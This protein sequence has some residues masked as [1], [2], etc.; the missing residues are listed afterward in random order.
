MSQTRLRPRLVWNSRN[1]TG[2]ASGRQ[3]NRSYWKRRRRNRTGADYC[4]ERKFEGQS[5]YENITTAQVA[6]VFELG[7]H[8]IDQPVKKALDVNDETTTMKIAPIPP[9]LVYD[10]FEQDLDATMV[11]ER[12]MDCQHDSPMRTNVLELFLHT[13]MIGQWR[14]ADIKPFLPA[15]QFHRMLSR[16]ARLWAATQM[17]KLLPE[18]S[19]APAPVTPARGPPPG[20][21][22]YRPQ[23]GAGGADNANQVARGMIQMDAATLRDFLTKAPGHR[24]PAPVTPEEATF[25]V[26]AAGGEKARMRAMCGIASDSGDECLPKWFR[27]FFT[28]HQDDISKSPIIAE[29]VNASWVLDDAEVPLYPSLLKSIQTRNWTAQDLGKRAALFSLQWSI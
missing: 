28:K 16:E 23:G 26:S 22:Q 25:K 4:T 11:Y 17:D 7:T 12:V 27:N 24:A 5:A 9:Y 21:L 29:V 8:R 20:G 13:C 19:L 15:E 6:T 2:V 14:T 1:W 18:L 3:A 10:G